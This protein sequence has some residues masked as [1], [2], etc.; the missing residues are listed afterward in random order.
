M[1]FEADMH[2][3]FIEQAG[4]TFQAQTL[5]AQAGGLTPGSSVLEAGCGTG[6]LMSSL[7]GISPALYTGVDVQPGLLHHAAGVFPGF[8]FACADGFC[9]PFANNQFDAVV[10]H[11][12]LL[13]VDN[14]PAILRE[15]LRVTRPGGFVGA[16]AEPDY[17]SRI[18]Y[19][20]DFESC[21]RAQ[22][23]SLI[24]QGAD[25][26]M[27][28][29][30]PAAL[31]EAG[32]VD[33]AYGILGAYLPVPL[34]EEQIRSEQSILRNDLSDSEM[35]RSMENILLYD[36]EARRRNT[37]VHFIPTFFGWGKKPAR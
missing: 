8:T 3:R 31:A 32:C 12:F 34:T 26:D 37:R 19:P 6:A 36:A 35:N 11:Y 5:F 10:C 17:G 25:P 7:A 24:R 29:K 30:V 16:L 23:D 18:D 27:G 4:W 21:G 14:V 22:R 15:M 20:V 28:R 9:L 13:W 1:R 33:I 2:E